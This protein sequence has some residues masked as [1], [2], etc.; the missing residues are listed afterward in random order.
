MIDKD[1][2]NVELSVK[3][4]ITHPRENREHGSLAA[5]KRR[6]KVGAKLLCVENTKRPELNGRFREVVKVQTNSFAWVHDDDGGDK[7]SWTDYPKAT[8]LMW[9][10]EHTFKIDMDGCG[11]GFSVTLRFVK[12]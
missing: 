8:G 11:S 1:L 5:L 2:T 7:R 12:L 4:G 3:Y 9:L 6:M 10:D